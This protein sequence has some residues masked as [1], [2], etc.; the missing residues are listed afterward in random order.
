MLRTSFV[1][2]SAAVLSLLCACGGDDR[3]NVTGSYPVTLNMSAGAG[4]ESDDLPESVLI[5]NDDSASDALRLKFLILKCDLGATMTG[6][7]SF[8]IKPGNCPLLPAD[9][10]DG[11]SVDI[12]V[13]SGSGSKASDEAP[14]EIT[15]QAKSVVACEGEEPIEAPVVLVL[16]GM[17]GSA[18]PGDAPEALG[19]P[20]DVAS[21]RRLF[22]AAR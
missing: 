3:E 2:T 14:I 10:G 5:S 19:R 16:R 17:S 1:V 9:E 21:L 18:L 4:S 13:E 7:R 6:E 15:L 22:P 11:C 8:S 20:V 12:K